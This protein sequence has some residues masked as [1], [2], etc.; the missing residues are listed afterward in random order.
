MQLNVFWGTG[1]EET[2]GVRIST[3]GK[4][5][6]KCALTEMIS[7]SSVSV[8]YSLCCVAYNPS[9]LLCCIELGVPAY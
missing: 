6:M 2:G 9:L 4:K 7:I 8:P 3:P 1:G 5:V